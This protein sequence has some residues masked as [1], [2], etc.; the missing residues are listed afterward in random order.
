[1]TFYQCPNCGFISQDANQCPACTDNNQKKL[2][3]EFETIE[4]AMEYAHKRKGG[5]Y[6]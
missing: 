4:D 3:D 1:M 5:F 6:G 2:G